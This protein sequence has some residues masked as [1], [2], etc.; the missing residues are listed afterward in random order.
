M[1]AFLARCPLPLVKVTPR[2]WQPW[3]STP[4]QPAL[5]LPRCPLPG[6][7]PLIVRGQC[8]MTHHFFPFSPISVHL[9]LTFSH[10]NSQDP[11]GITSLPS[12][13]FASG[14]PISTSA[15]PYRRGLPHIIHLHLQDG[16]ICVRGFGPQ[17]KGVQSYYIYN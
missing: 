15:Y 1:K 14:L 3:E 9:A 2:K 16:G 5:L 11:I 6:S 7:W 8:I 12:H 13:P 17:P 4:R 10:P